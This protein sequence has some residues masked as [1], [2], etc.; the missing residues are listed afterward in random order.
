M[1]SLVEKKYINDDD[2]KFYSPDISFPDVSQK[3]RTAPI[4]ATW[5]NMLEEK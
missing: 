5:Y 1:L 4:K 3:I 2:I